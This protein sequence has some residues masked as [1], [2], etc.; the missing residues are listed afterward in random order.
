M[1]GCATLMGASEV[2]SQIKGSGGEGLCDFD[3][4]FTLWAVGTLQH[5]K[6]AKLVSFEENIRKKILKGYFNSLKFLKLKIRDGV[7]NF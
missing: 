4:D 6:T 5:S 7:P 1:R 3:G 2:T